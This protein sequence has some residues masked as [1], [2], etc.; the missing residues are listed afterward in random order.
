MPDL[1]GRLA[2]LVKTYRERPWRSFDMI[3]IVSKN[4]PI[5]LTGCHP[6]KLATYLQPPLASLN[7]TIFYRAGWSLEDE[8]TFKDR[9]SAIKQAQLKFPRHH[10]IFSANTPHEVELMTK[11]GIHA[12]FLNENAFIDEFAFHPDNSEAKDFDAIIDAQIAPYKRLELAGS[13]SKLIV[14]TYILEGRYNPE[15]GARIRQAL[16]HATW[17]NGPYWDAQAYKKLNRA[18][19]S[20]IY[21]QARVGLCLSA[22]EGANLA[23]IQYLLSGL[24]VV[25][26]PS[27][28][29]REIFFSPDYAAVVPAEASAIAE[30]V[31]K[32]VHCCPTPQVI[33][34]KTLAKIWPIR[35]HFGKILSSAC[36]HQELDENWWKEFNTKR[37]ISYQNLKEVAHTLVQ[38]N[39]KQ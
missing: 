34:E 39:R 33:R 30:A 23:S 20:K 12:E 36:G 29:G 4:P 21:R 15:Y 13:I 25:S 14:V 37:P 19:V 22:V 26:S 18:E 17:A 6:S 9:V 7:L 5:L 1:S 16:T 32:F 24:A 2:R 38:A 3:S 10:Y 35:H 28:G 27:E 8:A 31:E 11:E